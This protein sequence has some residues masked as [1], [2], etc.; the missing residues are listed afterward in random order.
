MSHATAWISGVAPNTRRD[1]VSPIPRMAITAHR[2]PSSY[3]HILPAMGP[4]SPALG[5]GLPG[6]GGLLFPLERMN[7]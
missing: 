4:G 5:G 7:H 3:G 6:A 1:A 2:D